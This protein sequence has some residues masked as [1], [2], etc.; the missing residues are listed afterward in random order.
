[1]AGAGGL[2]LM[3]FGTLIGFG[4][5]VLAIALFWFGFRRLGPRWS[6]ALAI[7]ATLG[8]VLAALT[9]VPAWA[10]IVSGKDTRGEPYDRGQIP[11]WFYLVLATPLLTIAAFAWRTVRA[12]R[13][14]GTNHPSG[15]S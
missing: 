1:M 7:L 14:R 11:L 3:L 6:R 9:M 4:A 8:S 15:T 5:A 2:W 10:V 13:R 12:R